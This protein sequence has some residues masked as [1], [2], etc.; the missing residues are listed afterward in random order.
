MRKK[1]LLIPLALLLIVSLLACAAPA[2][3]P[4][5]TPAPTPAPA[6]LPAPV[7]APVPA[8]APTPAPSPAPAPAPAPTP[9]KWRISNCGTPE[10]P[11]SFGMAEFS[12]KV[13]D[14]TDG[15][16]DITP[17]PGGVLGSWDMTNEMVMRGDIEMILDALDDSFDP[18]LGIAYYM[19]YLLTGYDEAAKLW[20]VGGF[21]FEVMNEI[22]KPLGYQPLGAFA[23]GISG[24]TIKDRPP[25]P[26]DPD[27]PKNMK[28]RVMPLTAC[29]LTYE[30][31]GYMT[32][33]IPFG[34][35]YTSIQTGI[36]DGQMGGGPPQANA[37]RDVQGYYIHYQDY[38]EPNWFMVNSEAY[39][40]LTPADQKILLDVAQEVQKLQLAEAAAMDERYM[41]EFRDY[42]G[43]VI[44]LTSKELAACAAAVREDVW[45]ELVPLFGK[46]ILGKLCDAV[47]IERPW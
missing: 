20:P 19:P 13:R 35:T 44:L 16:V 10:M 12:D 5:P 41:Q 46:D 30:R 37:F 11:V 15:R 32:A 42:G 27:V 21:V 6:P 14:R 8:P 47:G 39:N 26:G 34:E 22:A 1:I 33:A 2:P 45:P 31:L 25:S 36:V 40:A 18:R 38:I 17:Y 7:P 43:E 29:R 4:A 9:V 23:C 24:M 3:A 28:I